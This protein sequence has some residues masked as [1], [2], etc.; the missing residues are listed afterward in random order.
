MT[1][2]LKPNTRADSYKW[3]HFRQIRP[4]TQYISSYIESRGVEV[5]RQWNSHVVAGMTYYLNEY[6]RKP[7]VTD[8]AITRLARR[9]ETHGVSFDEA[10]WR[11]I[12]NKHGGYAPVCI[13]AIAE[14]S[15]VPLKTPIVQIVNTDPAVPAIGPWLETQLL[16]SIWYPSTVATQSFHIKRIIRSYMQSTAGHE[17]GL[18]FKLHDF[19]ARGVSSSES[20]QIGGVAHLFNFKGSD[21][22]EAIEMAEEIYMEEMAGFSVD[23]AEHSTVTSFGGEQYEVEAYQHVLNQFGIGNKIF[24]V[25]SDSYD[26]Y[27]AIDNIYGKQLKEQV[28][29]LGPKGA[30]LVVRPDS[31]DP[32]IVVIDVINKLMDKFGY[33]LNSKGYKVLP[34]Y[35]GVLQGDGIN[36]TSIR[37]IL[38]QMKIARLSA[39]NVVFGMGGALLQGVNRDTLK[40]AMKA[41]AAKG[42][43]FNNGDWYDITKNPRTDPT[44]RSKGGRHA[45]IKSSDFADY[46]TTIPESQYLQ[47]Y[48]N[49]GFTN[50]LE[51]VYKNGEILKTY[52][53]EQIRT[54][55]DEAL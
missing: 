8:K 7:L 32:V 22:F 34:P 52:T 27:N 10:G 38:A 40:F 50:C 21:N 41:S 11:H 36:E 5:G 3:G 33:T 29:A 26:I 47:E 53:L 54:R 45:V 12:V 55:I 44:K 25:V 49:N 35:L 24:S 46:Y 30:K 48:K 31:G 37:Q 19:G 1:V 42:H 28:E 20:A 9:M 51:D 18:D 14:G 15:V 6:M 17:E 16:R 43:T 2:K 39:E 4:G 23:A 13:Q